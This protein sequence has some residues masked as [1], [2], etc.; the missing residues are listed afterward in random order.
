MTKAQVMAGVFISYSHKQ[1]K[2]VRQVLVPC[3]KAAGVE[4]NIDYERLEAAESLNDQIIRLQQES[5]KQILVLS[6][7][8][9]VSEVCM[10]EMIR[11]VNG[12]PGFRSGCIIPVKIDGSPLPQ[13]I[14]EPNPIVVNFFNRDHDEQWDLLF[15]CLGRN[16][17]SPVTSWLNN[18]DTIANNLYNKRSVGI[19]VPEFEPRPNW[20]FLI[21]HMRNDYVPELHEIDLEMGSTVTRT[22][23]IDCIL[24]VIGCPKSRLTRN[25]DLRLL[26]EGVSEFEGTAWL[27]LTHFHMV[28]YR[29]CYDANFFGALRHLV[30]RTNKIVLLVQSSISF[31]SVLPDEYRRIGF[32]ITTIEMK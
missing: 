9:Y 18:R 12:D 7:E 28:R 27:A 14:S 11:A 6:E 17:G 4:I 21:E 29:P 15:K 13:I 24:Q 5:H 1:S 32:G 10:A 23:L 31:S 2:W 30:L 20:H 25:N 19:I 26:H 3:L 16:L 8:Y 22:G